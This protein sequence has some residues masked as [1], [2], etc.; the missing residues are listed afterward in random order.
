MKHMLKAVGLLGAFSFAITAFGQEATSGQ[1]AQSEA[2]RAYATTAGGSMAS[3][4]MSGGMM[5]GGEGLA[6]RQISGASEL[7][8]R[9]QATTLEESGGAMTGGTMTGGMMS[10]GAMTGGTS[11]Q[12]GQLE[13][14][15]Q[16]AVACLVE[17]RTDIEA[18]QNAEEAALALLN[19]REDLDQTFRAAQ[20]VQES[21]ET[22]VELEL[23]QQQVSEQREEALT[24]L[25]QV[26]EKENL[27]ALSAGG[28]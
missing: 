21:S 2:C 16:S 3:E 24:T 11:V 15:V 26:T 13:N 10:G 23:L 25:D 17:L 14:A 22:L 18:G 8:N 27:S 4:T 7:E 19:I 9:A 20:V 6:E 28:Q 5:S 1:G 12:A